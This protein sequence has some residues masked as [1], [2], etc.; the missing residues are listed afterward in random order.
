MFEVGKWHYTIVRTA[1]VSTSR[2]ST[3]GT[4]CPSRRW[5]TASRVR[6]VGAGSRSATYSRSAASTASRCTRYAS[7]RMAARTLEMGCYGIGVSRVAAAAIEQEPRR[8]R[9]RLAGRHRAARSGLAPAERAPLGPGAGT[10]G[11]AVRRTRRGRARSP[12]GRPPH[13][14][15]GH[16]LRD[17]PHRHPHRLVPGSGGPTKGSSSTGA[18]AAANRTDSPRASGDGRIISLWEFPLP[19]TFPR[20]AARCRV[21]GSAP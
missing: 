5:R 3:G 15:G 18:G 10:G 13:S 19:G 2:A 17:G 8:E 9:D 4:T 21:G 6:T 20:C 12:A 1:A 16:V 14:A 11:S 7:T